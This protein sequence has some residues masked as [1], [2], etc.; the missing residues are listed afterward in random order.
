YSL[1]VM[2]Y[3]ILTERQPFDAETAMQLLVKVVEHPPPPPSSVISEEGHPARDPRL[4]A[5][6]LQALA[7]KPE[8][9]PATAREFAEALSRWLEAPAVPLL[10]PTPRSRRPALLF[11]VAAVVVP[12]LALTALLFRS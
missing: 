11:G 5:L 1:G 3:E 8:E 4:E 12:A 2:M 6:C 9:R 7:K 10:K